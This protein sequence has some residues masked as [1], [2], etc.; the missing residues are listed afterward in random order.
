MGSPIST[1]PPRPSSG[2]PTQKP[3]SGRPKIVL[4]LLDEGQEFQRL[5]A[6]DAQSAAEEGGLDVEVLYAEN[7]AVVQIQQ[8]YQVVHAPADRRPSVVIVHTVAGEGLERLAR[9]A[10]RAGIGWIVLNR[11]VA[12]L[13]ELRHQQPKLPIGMIG[14]DNR[15]IGRI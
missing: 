4:G 2:R 5:Q 14:S 8:L 6:E 12:Y 9:T 3:Q 7:N 10:V 11:R 13:D 1:P 15:E